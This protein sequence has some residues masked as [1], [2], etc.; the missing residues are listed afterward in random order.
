LSRPVVT[1][2]SPPSWLQLTALVRRLV[3]TC[4]RRSASPWQTT[5]TK[6][7]SRQLPGHRITGLD[8]LASGPARGRVASADFLRHGEI[9]S[10][11]IGGWDCACAGEVGW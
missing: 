10:V 7:A 9:P 11:G 6:S 2:T 5:V 4:A 1:R 8:R 3:T